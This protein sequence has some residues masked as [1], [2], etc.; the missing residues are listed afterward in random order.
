MKNNA[1]YV[2][3]NFLEDY[4]YDM[5]DAGQGIITSRDC[6]HY[7]DNCDSCISVNCPFNQIPDSPEEQLY[8]A[9][10]PVPEVL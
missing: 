3:I 4:T 9:A 2:L 8:Y 6:E 1:T 10:H 7:P 5:A